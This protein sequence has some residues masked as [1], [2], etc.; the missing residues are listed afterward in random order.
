M[1]QRFGHAAGPNVLQQ[2]NGYNNIAILQAMAV[3][4]ICP[5]NCVANNWYAISF[6]DQLMNL[7]REMV[8]LWTIW[9]RHVELFRYPEQLYA[10]GP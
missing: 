6:T 3:K 2:D 9:K 4:Y 10:T 8:W 7:I 5:Y 1:G